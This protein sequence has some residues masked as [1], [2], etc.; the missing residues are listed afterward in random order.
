MRLNRIRTRLAGVAGLFLALYSCQL[1]AVPQKL[2]FA[3]NIYYGTGENH[4]LQS[5]DI[6]WRRHDRPLPVIVY[7]HG[8]G[9][10][11]GDKT[12]VH[13]QPDFFTAHSLV[14]ISMNYRLRW[15]HTVYDQLEDIVSVV[16]WVAGNSRKYGMDPKR[17]CL[18]G[19]G[20]GA[21]LV[22][23][24]ATNPGLL[25][26]EGLNPRNIRCVVSIDNAAFD[27]GAL[28]NGPGN[29]PE[30]RR[31]RLIFGTEASILADYSPIT[32]LRAGLTVPPFAIVYRASDKP[33]TQQSLGFAKALQAVGNK[34]LLIPN[35]RKSGTA[36]NQ[37]IGLTNDGPTRALMVF[38]RGVM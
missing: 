14:F 2:N 29:F 26:S 5:L 9:W 38:I 37:E 33:Q 3:R 35:R 34:V 15:A 6:Y 36:M 11:F 17:I 8:G 21:L 18:M 19:N 23:L 32:H 24:V 27:L 22:S 10:A 16:Q 30:K 7:V 4:N 31:Y 12:D 28:M 25:S 13:H 20:A 1:I